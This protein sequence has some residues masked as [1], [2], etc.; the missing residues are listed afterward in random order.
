MYVRPTA[1]LEGRADVAGSHHVHLV[2]Y[3]LPCYK[4]VQREWNIARSEEKM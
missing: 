4:W 1:Y 3:A 2:G